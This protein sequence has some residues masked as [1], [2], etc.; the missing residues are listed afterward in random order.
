MVQLALASPPQ[1]LLGAGTMEAGMQAT[2]MVTALG[3]TV[4]VV[5]MGMETGAEPALESL[6]NLA[7]L[8]QAAAILVLLGLATIT[9]TEMPVTEMVMALETTMPV[10]AMAME[11][12]ALVA[13]LL[14]AQVVALVLAA[15]LL[16][17]LILIQKL[18]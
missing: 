16:V 11:T 5:G 9:A 12:E 1:Q 10:V 6:Q 7:T 17:T 13:L 2:G 14:E 18:S 4:P 3:T 15:S 8:A